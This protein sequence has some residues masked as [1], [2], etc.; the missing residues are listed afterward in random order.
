MTEREIP[1]VEFKE[2]DLFEAVQLC[3]R[4]QKTL[5]NILRT[6][7]IVGKLLLA[8]QYIDSFEVRRQ[9]IGEVPP[10]L[11]RRSQR[12]LGEDTERSECVIDGR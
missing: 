5:C 2:S 1:N 4:L 10:G 3:F 9:E 11:E 12:L 8:D 6:F 7:R